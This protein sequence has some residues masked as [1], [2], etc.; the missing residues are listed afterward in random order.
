MANFSIVD[1]I[2]KFLR[3]AAEHYWWTPHQAIPLSTVCKVQIRPY[4]SLPEYK[5]DQYIFSARAT[6]ITMSFQ[7]SEPSRLRGSL[8]FL[9][10]PV[11]SDES[12]SKEEQLTA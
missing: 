9:Y 2:F 11:P 12:A 5:G 8:S 7:N 1:R 10:F 6:L 4:Q 3:Y